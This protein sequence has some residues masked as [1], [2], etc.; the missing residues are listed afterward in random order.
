[1]RQEYQADGSNG[2]QQK[3][4]LLLVLVTKPSTIAAHRGHCFQLSTHPA[5]NCGVTLHMY[6]VGKL[7]GADTN[8]YS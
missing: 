7:I 2:L 4:F 5:F 8:L 6:I 3:I 1:M